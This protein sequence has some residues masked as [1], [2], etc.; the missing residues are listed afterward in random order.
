MEQRQ[1]Q[2]RLKDNKKLRIILTCIGVFLL[3]AGIATT[4]LGFVLFFVNNTIEFPWPIF[5]G[6]PCIFFGFVLIMLSNIG[7]M[8]RFVA[9]QAVPV[10]GDATA[11]LL[12]GPAGDSMV[13]VG[14]RVV[15]SSRQSSGGSDSV[16]G[17]DTKPCGRCGELN[18][19]DARFCE[20]CGEQFN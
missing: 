10:A 7:A 1:Q 9:A 2:K 12:N 8:N 14:S 20:R 11:D 4:V 18:K 6:F 5:I 16:S 19:A 3:L 15:N 17:R 13:N